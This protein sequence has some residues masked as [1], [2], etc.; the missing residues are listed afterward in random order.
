MAKAN[1]EQAAK[2]IF[3]IYRHPF[4]GKKLGRFTLKRDQ[5]GDLLEVATV[6]DTTITKLNDALLNDYDL[7]LIE[8]H[9]SLFGVV[10][11]RKVGAWRKLPR[12]VLAQF[13]PSPTKQSPPDEEDD[14]ED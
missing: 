12:S 6:H 1:I 4:S 7:C 14:F 9:H 13:T 3:E 10:S 5:I 8:R 2:R 11:G